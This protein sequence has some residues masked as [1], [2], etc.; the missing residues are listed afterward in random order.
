MLLLFFTASIICM[1]E[2]SGKACHKQVTNPAK[3][4]VANE[5]PYPASMGPVMDEIAV[6]EPTEAAVGF[7]L[8]SLEGPKLLKSAT[9]P[10]ASTAPTVIILSASAGVVI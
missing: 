1:L 2:N 8:P 6:P 3:F 10:E 9:V 7:T 5:V 4:G